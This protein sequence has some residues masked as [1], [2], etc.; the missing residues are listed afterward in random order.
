MSVATEFAPVVFIPEPARRPEPEWPLADVLVLHAPSE[1]SAPPLRLT[2]RGI[3]AIVGAV[4]VAA[5]GLILG[6]WLSS[7]APV[8]GSTAPAT[9]TVQSG[10]TLWAIANRVAPQA[11]PRAEVAHLQALNHLTGVELVVGQHLRTR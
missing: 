10:D 6:A 3:R 2:P 1:V 5:V 9:V 7:P 11:D 8:H 4:A